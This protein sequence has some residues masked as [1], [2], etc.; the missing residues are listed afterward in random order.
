MTT[1]YRA[2]IVG[3]GRIGGFYDDE[4]TPRQEASFWR[5]PNRHAGLYIVLPV[6]H[7]A[8]YQSSPGFELVAAANRG[9]EKLR[10][11]GERYGVEALYPDVR[12]MLDQE[13]PDVVSVC[14][15]SPEKPE[16]TLAAAEPDVKAVVV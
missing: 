16:V 13:G 10:A 12:T 7:A 14:T 4:V 2:A 9:P 8:A 11:F 6:N 1:T 5:G 15:Q 3:T